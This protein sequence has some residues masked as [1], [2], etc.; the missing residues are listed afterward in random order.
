MNEL[1]SIFREFDTNG[2]GKLTLKDLRLGLDKAGYAVDD[3]EI[4]QLMVHM[5]V[6]RDGV[7][8]YDEFL[9]TMIDWLQVE[10]VR[11]TIDW[12]P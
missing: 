6:N 2:D 10:Q 4:E 8:Y 1:Y 11:H 12:P 5:D 3:S 9:A 7:V